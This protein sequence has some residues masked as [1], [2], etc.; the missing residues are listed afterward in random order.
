MYPPSLKTLGFLW[1]SML[2]P[3]GWDVVFPVKSSPFQ[4]ISAADPWVWLGAATRRWGI[5]RSKKKKNSR[6]GAVQT[7]VQL[8]SQTGGKLSPED[9]EAPG[10]HIHRPWRKH[11][12]PELCVAAACE[13]RT[14]LPS[15]QRNYIATEKKKKKKLFSSPNSGPFCNAP[16]CFVADKIDFR[17]ITITRLRRSWR[18]QL[19]VGLVCV[20]VFFSVKRTNVSSML[21][22]RA[23][24]LASPPV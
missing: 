1:P 5:K 9:E 4:T 11:N 16:H 18:R 24:H 20:C 14:R 10:G 7:R 17:S 23:V 3:Y 22:S 8:R 15:W 19:K 6:G 13:A 12:K 2:S 21:K